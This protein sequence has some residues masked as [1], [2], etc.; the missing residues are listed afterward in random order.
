MDEEDY[1]SEEE[2]AAAAA[3]SSGSVGGKGGAVAV[4][5]QAADGERE[6]ARAL[7]VRE[8]ADVC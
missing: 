1:R 7:L 2:E 3:I 4:A 6:A 8:R 5:G